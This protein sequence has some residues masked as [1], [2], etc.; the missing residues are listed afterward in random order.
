[1]ATPTCCDRS[2]CSS[3]TDSWVVLAEIP[4]EVGGELDLRL[5]L[6]Q[7]AS[8]TKEGDLGLF[9]AVAAMMDCGSSDMIDG[10][11]YLEMFP[12]S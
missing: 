10:S 4:L 2:C 11:C 12:G 5:N 6:V 9:L 3:L 7:V 8:S 1:M